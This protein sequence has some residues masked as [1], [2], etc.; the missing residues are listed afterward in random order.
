LIPNYNWKIISGWSNYSCKVISHKISEKKM[1]YRGSKSKLYANFVKEQ[2]VDGSWC[3]NPNQTLM[4]LRCTL[5]DFERNYQIKNPSKQLNIKNFSSLQSNTK[6]N[7]WF[8]TGFADA[9]STFT[10]IIDKNIKCNIGWRV[11]AKFQIGLNLHDLDLLLKIQQ[12]FGGIGSI[13]KS[14]NTVFYSISSV[15]D[16]TNI[17]IPHFEA[18]SLLTQKRADFLLFKQVV[19]LINNKDHLT[20]EGL[21]KIINLKAS[22][23][24]GISDIVKSNFNNTD[25]V[26]RPIIKIDNIIDP[27]WVT[28]F[29]NG[30]GSFDIKIYSSKTKIKQAVQLR[31]RIP[32][33]ERDTKLIDILIKYFDSGTKEK[34]TKFPLITLVIVK[35]KVIT[36]TIIPFFEL[37]PMIGKKQ[38]D[39][40]DWCKIAKL[41]KDD[42]HLT[43]EGL[44][45]IQQIKAGMNKRRK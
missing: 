21:I 44:N 12:F 36:E 16:L 23:N 10:I 38:L 6:M 24:L 3:I 35:F 28:G 13:S 33:H 18:F 29:V 4:H 31:F 9:E 14:G 19:E 20:K 8:I 34:H 15:K 42:Y 43:I 32:Q 5:M 39:Y 41:M 30:E 11:Q 25:P 1:G 7:P 27:H 2:R 37:Y 40:L 22:M 26:E 45:L 17:I